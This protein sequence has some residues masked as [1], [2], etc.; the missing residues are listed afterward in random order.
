[1]T[2]ELYESICTVDYQFY[3]LPHGKSKGIFELMS[4]V[5]DDNEVGI[6]FRYR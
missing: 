4:G 5:K 6:K 2:M 3:D 1:M